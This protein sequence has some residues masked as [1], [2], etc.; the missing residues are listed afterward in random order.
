MTTLNKYRFFCQTEGTYVYVWSDVL[1]TKCPNNTSDTIDSSSISIVE[2]LD[3]KEVKVKEE[4]TPT[5]GHFQATTLKLL[6]TANGVS[7]INVHWPYNITAFGVNFVT[8]DVHKGDFL[9]MYVGKDT[10]VG[11][12]GMPVA[13]ASAWLNQN[14]TAGQVVTYFVNATYGTRVY[15]CILDT[16]SNEVPTNTT[17]WRHGYALTVSSTVL[18]YS[19]TGFYLTLDDGTN[20]DNMGRIISVDESLSRVYMEN[21]PVNSFSPATPTYI[22]QTVYLIDNFEMGDSWARNIGEM[23]IGGSHIPKDTVIEVAYTNNSPTDD[24]TIIGHVEYLY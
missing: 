2:K 16:V 21:N 15:T 24:K 13:P 7:T 17:Y 19:K 9:S 8:T 18:E 10:V 5:G 4:A 23:K 20:Q 12:I 11:A 3:T 22:K 1:P 14:Y 6:A